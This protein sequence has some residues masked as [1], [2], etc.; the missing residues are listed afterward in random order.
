MPLF[1]SKLI[2][3]D[4]PPAP[5]VSPSKSSPY[6][7]HEECILFLNG[8]MKNL[9]RGSIA[10]V[11]KSLE[12]PFALKE[13]P[14][15][16]HLAQEQEWGE[17]FKRSLEMVV[18]IASAQISIEKIMKERGKLQR[19]LDHLIERNGGAFIEG[20][21][22]EEFEI[23]SLDC[24]LTSIKKWLAETQNKPPVDVIPGR[25][26]AIESSLAMQLRGN[27]QKLQK[28]QLDENSKEK[29]L[30]TQ[31]RWLLQQYEQFNRKKIV[32]AMERSKAEQEARRSGTDSSIG[33]QSTTSDVGFP[34]GS[35][36]NKVGF[37]SQVFN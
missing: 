5:P 11:I 1:P 18:A 33:Y 35:F 37:P 2:F 10:A 17:N 23:Q 12:T 26:L 22:P 28:A 27:S 30:E 31:S 19:R 16:R 20:L 29:N 7:P 9:S 24:Q 3:S 36:R 8:D 25:Q 6:T 15:Y 21:Y 13:L 32:K 4:L 14:Q 34:V